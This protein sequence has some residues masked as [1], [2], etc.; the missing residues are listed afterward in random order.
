MPNLNRTLLSVG[1]LFLL[2]IAAVAAAPA[3]ATER[4]VRGGPGGG[5]FRTDCG[6][7]Y[8]VG[9]YARAGFWIDAIGLKCGSFGPD[10]KWRQPAGNRAYHG[11]P[12]G[13][14][15]PDKL[16]P[17]TSYISGLMF[18]FT[19]DGN[20]PKY[21]DFVEMT[22]TNLVTGAVTRVCLETGGGCPIGREGRDDWL[23][24]TTFIAAKT[25]KC[26]ASEAMTG[27]NGRSGTFVDAIGM[28]CG[29]KPKL[30][31]APPPPPPKCADNEMLI[32]GKCG[33][34]PILPGSNTGDGGGFIQMFPT[35]AD[36]QTY[37]KE[38]KKCVA[39]AT[40]PPPP[41]P[42]PAQTCS[43]DK[44]GAVYDRPGGNGKKIGEI[45]VGTQG[46][47]L[48]QKDGANW[49][50]LKWPAGEGWVY[51]GPGYTNAVKC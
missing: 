42:P 19:R 17:T 13:G 16:C 24:G 48:L 25:Q 18:G 38:Q 27:L 44:D 41:P 15:T 30:A 43:I 29:P 37:N 22:C 26:P 51:S 9:L 33:P 40:T 36:G 14:L 34:I 8:V 46:V 20:D 47:T 2:M 31:A 10:N 5:P 45:G 50:K 12:G 39:N 32:K 35:C 1:L 3:H 28:I 7:E 21:L 49:F 23:L 6:S 4:A 11:G